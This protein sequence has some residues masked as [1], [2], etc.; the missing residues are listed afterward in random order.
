MQPLEGQSPLPLRR[1]IESTGTLFRIARYGPGKAVFV[2]GDPCE[3]VM[4]I[5]DG[6]VELSVMATDGE[7]AICG[8]LGVGAFL[9]EEALGARAT[10]PH[11][12]I[13]ITETEMI[14]V[15]KEK[16]IQ[17]VRTQQAI[18]DRL[19]A[20]V[21]ARQARLEEDLTDQLLHSCEQRLARTLLMLAGCDEHHPCTCRLPH[22]SQG[23][24]AIMVGTTRSR[25]NVF[26]GRFKKLGWIEQDGGDLQVTGS[27][28]HFVDTGD[29]GVSNGTSTVPLRALKFQTEVIASG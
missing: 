14:V 10:R 28:L 22:V 5:E 25:V 12:A 13:A 16:M 9:G 3:T 1:L 17:L 24:I 27:L 4:H 11:T 6:C 20:H 23:E 18:A 2:Q 29:R 21:L 19:V 7:E 26:I 15:A 8:R